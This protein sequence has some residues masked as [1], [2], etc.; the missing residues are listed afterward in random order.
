MPEF[1]Y[2]VN[3]DDKAIKRVTSEEAHS[4]G[5]L[6]R[7]VLVVIGT[8][9]SLEKILLCENA[10]KTA[11]AGKEQASVRENVWVDEE[12][13]EAAEKAILKQLFYGRT[14]MPKDIHLTPLGKFRHKTVRD[15]A[16]GA[17]TNNEIVCA[18]TAVYGG[19]VFPNPQYIGVNQW[20]NRDAI[21]SAIL[22][23]DNHYT[24]TFITFMCVWDRYL[25]RDSTAFVRTD[26]FL[27]FS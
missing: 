9:P 11:A 1:V 20:A 7:A 22:A 18:F 25:K 10:E 15:S 12:Y 13:A 21:M 5:L 24:D 27:Q 16:Q 26:A 19:K 4:N 14:R 6:H 8:S 2:H 17:R 3:D 23:E